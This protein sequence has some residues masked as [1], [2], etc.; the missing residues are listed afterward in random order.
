M[1]QHI[2]PRRTYLASLDLSRVVSRDC[3]IYG[4][5]GCGQLVKSNSDIT[6]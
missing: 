5:G 6:W 2:D 4:V 1:L 3:T